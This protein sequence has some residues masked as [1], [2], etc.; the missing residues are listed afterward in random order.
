MIVTDAR[1]RRVLTAAALASYAA[2]FVAFALFERPGTGI[3]HG[4]YVAIVLSGMAWGSLGGTL[5][6]LVAT[7]LY[8]A[9]V[10]TNDQ[11]PTQFPPES[12]AIRLA[13]YVL[14]GWLIGYY[15][16]RSRAL[17]RKADELARELRLLARRDFV[18]GL[19]NQRAFELAVNRRIDA[20]A[21]FVLVVCDLPAGVSS[22]EHTDRLLDLSQRLWRTV[23]TETDVARI[24]EQQFG[25]LS[26]VDDER[27]SAALTGRIER[28]LADGG[29]RA[30]AGWATFPRDGHD[31]L[32]LY[33]GANERLYARKIARGEWSQPVAAGL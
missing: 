25:V 10:Y 7:G 24:G 23:G 16:S 30:T 32:G 31:A 12:T 27:S 2:V 6:G 1:M 11:V 9:G 26:P 4:Y 33:N 14:V 29:R 18:T 21:P 17:L 8:L 13:T 5:G 3:G 20:A 28:A 22:L 19:P 15:A